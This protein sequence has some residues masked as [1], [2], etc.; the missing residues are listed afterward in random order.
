MTIDIYYSN[1]SGKTWGI[2][3][4]GVEN[5]G[6]Y[7][8]ENIRPVIFSENGNFY[9]TLSSHARIKVVATDY[10]RNFMLR[11]QDISDND[12]CPPVDCDLFTLGTSEKRSFCHSLGG[13][14]PGFKA[15]NK[16]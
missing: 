10:T 1:D 3:E 6:S 4:K 2:I 7:L 8:W 13:G 12:F 16:L 5:N 14:N 15:K 11:G 9:S